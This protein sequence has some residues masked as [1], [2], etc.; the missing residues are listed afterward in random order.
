[1]NP[2]VHE[3][4]DTDA[5][6]DQIAVYFEQR[7]SWEDATLARLTPAQRDVGWGDHWIGFSDDGFIFGRVA[8]V[9]EC[10]ARERSCGADDEEIADSSREL[11]DAYGRGYRLGHVFG[12]RYREGTFE[13]MHL[14]NIAHRITPQEFAV[15]RFY[16]WDITA[17]RR[18][19]VVRLHPDGNKLI[20]TV[21]TC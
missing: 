5:S 16:G 20:F 14:S 4:D 9:E 3:A 11:S 13:A 15:A 2:F 12:S 17:M 10:A 7:K 6:V 19:G 21:A 18:A 1:M 8:T